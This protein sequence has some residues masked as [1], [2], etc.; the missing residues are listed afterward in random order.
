VA[1]P[2]PSSFVAALTFFAAAC[3]LS[4]CA[5]PLGPGYIVEKQEVRVTFLPQPQPLIHVTA[6]YRLKNTGNQQLDT[7]TVRL[8][9]RRFNPGP[10]AVSCDGVSLPFL[11]APENPRDTLIR[12][13][14]PWSI[15]AGHQ[16][17]F[18]Y[19]IRS[20]SAAEESFS[21][22]SDAF[23]LPAEGWTPSLPQ[24]PGVFGF[25]G[26]PPKK[27]QLIVEAPQG[28]L[29]HASGGKEKRSRQNGQV[30]L[31]FEQTANDL[32]PFIVAGRYLETRQDLAENQKVHIWSRAALN[33]R[34][35]QQAGESLSKALATYDSLFGAR[36]K[37]RPPLWIV[38]C[39]AESGCLTKR[40]TGYALLLYGT[41][42][43][44]STEMISRDT[45]VVDSRL[46]TGENEALT[47]PA[48]AAGWL[49]YGQNPGFYEQRPPMSALPAF[50]IALVREKTL[51]TQVRAQTIQ[52]ALAQIPSR[53]SRQSNNDPVV[54]RAKSLLL[55][56]A[57]RDRVGAANF[58][59]GMQHMLAARRQRGFDI[60]DLISALE[61]ETRQ[62]IGP[63]V[64][65]WIKR[66]GVPEDFRAMYSQSTARRI[67]GSQEAIP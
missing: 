25:G 16:L 40:D 54:S 17:Q 49:G 33:S 6:D 61:Q 48:L 30:E 47:G 11:S 63:F 65:E 21:F 44:V 18:A 60:T 4:A 34:S 2:T 35:L 3:W 66:P 20:A 52:R 26:V 24:A 58:Q 13:A 67:S 62:D 41:E 51:G 45:V 64:R 32:S 55:F 56:Y 12:F 57:L 39:P 42:N 27:W 53:A 29:V 8:P 59:K 23:A 10:L 19:D 38:D 14:N 5:T 22:S 36:G 28:F 31:R 37:S 1:R 50:A 9:G 15:G 7:L 43:K 46:A